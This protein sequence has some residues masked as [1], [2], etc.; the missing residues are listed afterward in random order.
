MTGDAPGD[1]ARWLAG[2]HGD[3]RARGV[4]GLLMIVI[5]GVVLTGWAAG[6]RILTS[7]VV[8]GPAMRPGVAVGL[9]AAGAALVLDALTGNRGR[10]AVVLLLA[11]VT[12]LGGACVVVGV[13]GGGDALETLIGSEWFV[14]G[15]P[16][17]SD[18]IVP[19]LAVSGLTASLGL[20]DRRWAEAAAGI[21]FACGWVGLVWL[22][23]SLQDVAPGTRVPTSMPMAIAL[24]LAGSASAVAVPGG[25]VRRLA[26]EDDPAARAARVL[27]PLALLAPAA[28]TVAVE[29]AALT[30]TAHGSAVVAA[31]AVAMTAGAVAISVRLAH[32]LAVADRARRALITHLQATSAQLE[33]AVAER[34][35][36]LVGA[37]ERA[38]TLA[39]SAP[40]GI[41]ETDDAGGCSYVND[42]YC[43]IFGR[44]RDQLLGSA[45]EAAVHPGD[46]D[47]L[48]R[49]WQEAVA[50]RREL[51]KEHRILLPSGGERWV[52]G[53]AVPLPG[54][55]GWIG[56]V[57]DITDQRRAEESDRFAAELFRGAFDEATIGVVLIDPDGRI[58]RANASMLALSGHTAEGVVGLRLTDLLPPAT[59][60][61]WPGPSEH[62]DPAPV[63]VRLLRADGSLLWVTL[64]ESTLTLPGAVAPHRLLQMI[65]VTEHRRS[66]EQLSHV[67]MHDPLT[68]LINRRAFIAAIESHVERCERY[69][70]TGAVL[71]LDLD[72]FKRINDVHGHNVGDQ[73]I[74]TIAELLSGRLRRTDVV[75]RLGGDEFAVLLPDATGDEARAVA[76]SVVGMFRS[77]T[78]TVSGHRVP[79]T[80][81]VGLALF[82]AEDRSA[83]EVLINADLAMYD[84]KEEGRGG[85]SEY[86]PDQY[87]E[88][89]TRHRL[90]WINRV[91]QAL[92]DD[93]FVLEAQPIVDLATG[94]IAQYELLLRMVGDG[95]DRIPPGSFLC[96]AERFG[97]MPRI[98][99]WVIERALDLL[100]APAGSSD[101]LPVLA[102][103]IS[104]P[105]LGEPELL[106]MI[107]DR[108]RAGRIDPKRLVFEVT[109]TAAVANIAAA[110]TFATR[111]RRLGCR[112]AL[113]DF[114][115]GFGSFYY[116][117]YLP[118]DEIKIDGEFVA[119][120]V[121]NPTD[122]AILRSIVGLAERLGKRTVAEHVGSEQVAGY[123]RE[124]GVDLGQGFHL[125]RPVPL[126]AIA[127]LNASG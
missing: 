93:G 57:H 18:L 67:T 101:T 55:R 71:M 35:G 88:P 118:F 38:R 12:T 45:W 77:N 26:G 80:S 89:R 41:F 122:Q 107:E 111:M 83:E 100:E 61:E 102:V 98:D 17:I 1:R 24:V 3:P 19:F 2:G 5:A 108:L 66:E 114:G 116:L 50:A 125:G 48:R 68:G 87:D 73:V 16:R 60:V 15:S 84:A 23:V 21:T 36:E 65:D 99:R 75:A 123:L 62:D 113:D 49:G 13:L 47:M 103:N 52:V 110:R 32:V 76:D 46:I 79:L 37:L 105:G 121:E 94:R 124:L 120:C 6:S 40:V 90:E 81:S 96:V 92:D 56:T 64:H 27:L 85:W 10:R 42:R 82:D 34:T 8:N 22:V 70:P 127:A 4:A 91:E 20:R 58:A 86:R 9:A 7:W 39:D 51:V 104:G 14:P 115:A 33:S 43:E 53:R 25:Q 97:L 119:S 11:V 78:T 31:I 59:P 28:I 112:F 95:S 109:E 44:P 69:G 117:K 74:V 126:P 29:R 106:E 30:R 63:P 54:C 72:H